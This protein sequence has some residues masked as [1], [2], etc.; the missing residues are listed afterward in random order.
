MRKLCITCESAK[1]VDASFGV[2]MHCKCC[3]LDVLTQSTMQVV[4]LDLKLDVLHSCGKAE[5]A[6][7]LRQSSADTRIQ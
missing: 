1:V 5:G 4:I 3:V 7:Y 2:V 6:V